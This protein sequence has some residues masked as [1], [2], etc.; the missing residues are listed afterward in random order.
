MFARNFDVEL[1]NT[2]EDNIRLG[3][4]MALPYPIEGR[5]SV[6]ARITGIISY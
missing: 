1:V 2:T 4:D 5:F 3:R 6:K